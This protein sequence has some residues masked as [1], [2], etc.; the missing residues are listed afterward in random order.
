M[1]TWLQAWYANPEICMQSYSSINKWWVRPEMRGNVSLLIVKCMH[2]TQHRKY[3]YVGSEIFNLIRS[4]PFINNLWPCLK[5]Q[6]HLSQGNLTVGYIG[7][8]PGD[9]ELHLICIKWNRL[10]LSSLIWMCCL[11]KIQVCATLF[12]VL[13]TSLLKVKIPSLHGGIPWNAL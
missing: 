13:N 6:V 9:W 3:L 5:A 2:N 8:F 12:M 7:N 11:W 4:V 1:G 10:C